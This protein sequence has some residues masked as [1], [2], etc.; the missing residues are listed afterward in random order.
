MNAITNLEFQG[1]ML[2][3]YTN[4]QEQHKQTRRD[5]VKKQIWSRDLEHKKIIV[6]YNFIPSTPEDQDR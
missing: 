6:V 5:L 1:K 3:I 4:R 2:L